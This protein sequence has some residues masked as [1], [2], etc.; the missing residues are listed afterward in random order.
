MYC[1]TYEVILFLLFFFILLYMN[2]YCFVFFSFFY[3]NKF[4]M[5][6]I[7]LLGNRAPKNN[8]GNAPFCIPHG[9]CGK[10]ELGVLFK[11]PKK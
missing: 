7:G 6:D 8:F 5:G 11:M 3:V 1:D 10:C 2:C 9:W 4:L